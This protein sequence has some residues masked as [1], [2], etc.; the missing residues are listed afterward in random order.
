MTSY[1]AVF[2]YTLISPDT[3]QGADFNHVSSKQGL[4]LNYSHDAP[5]YLGQTYDDRV[6]HTEEE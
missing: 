3:H 6:T 5:R 2:N 1:L 4:V